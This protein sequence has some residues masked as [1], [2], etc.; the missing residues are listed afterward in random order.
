[1]EISIPPNG[2]NILEDKKSHQPNTVRPNNVASDN[3]P[4]ESEH[5]TPK[6]AQALIC[7]NDAFFL[8]ILRSSVKK[9]TDISHIDIVDVSDARNNNI[10]NNTDHI[11]APGI[12][13]NT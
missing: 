1:M 4:N 10:K 13:W 5:N 3:T 12:C 7:N 11:Y 8:D 2:S 6:T 9:A